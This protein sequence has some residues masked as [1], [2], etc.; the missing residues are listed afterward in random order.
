M[1][2]KTFKYKGFY[3]SVCETKNWKAPFIGTLYSKR[4]NKSKEVF[5]PKNITHEFGEEQLISSM[6]K[7]VDRFLTGHREWL[8]W[9]IQ[10]LKEFLNTKISELHFVEQSLK[11]E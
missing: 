10:N 9:K 2:R 1:N 4:Y 8:Q 7:E 6:E 5:Y 11:E 3:L